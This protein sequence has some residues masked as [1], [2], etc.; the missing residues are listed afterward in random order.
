MYFMYKPV[1][2]VA[3]V[4][5]AIII[6]ITACNKAGVVLFILSILD[7]LNSPKTQMKL[8]NMLPPTDNPVPVTTAPIHYL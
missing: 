3:R 8:L 4:N 6:T 7:R 1:Y 5:S 2:S